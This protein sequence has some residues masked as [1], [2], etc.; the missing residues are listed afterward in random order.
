MMVY[1]VNNVF[2]FFF[3]KSYFLQ[4]SNSIMS[5]QNREIL[6][7]WSYNKSCHIQSSR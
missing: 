5:C 1:I 3:R 6:F 7:T 2:E 4:N